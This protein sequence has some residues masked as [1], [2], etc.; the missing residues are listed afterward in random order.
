MSGMILE[1]SVYCMLSSYMYLGVGSFCGPQSP[2]CWWFYTRNT[3]LVACFSLSSSEAYS[4]VRSYQG[5]AEKI[6]A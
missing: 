5:P 4:K 2:C 1:I 6:R 3:V